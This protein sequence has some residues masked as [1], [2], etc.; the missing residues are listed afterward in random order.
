[1]RCACG[2]PRRLSGRSDRC[3]VCAYRV[4]VANAEASRIER[5]FKRAQVR[6][7]ALRRAA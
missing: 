2:R 6:R 4:R 7:V 5:V 3:S 1:M